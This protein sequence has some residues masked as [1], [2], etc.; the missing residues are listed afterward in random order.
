MMTTY[1]GHN[2][3]R[4]LLRELNQRRMAAGMVA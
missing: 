4:S 3:Q 2:A 1:R